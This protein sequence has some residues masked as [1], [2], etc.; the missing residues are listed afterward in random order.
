MA[1]SITIFERSAAQRQRQVQ[2]SKAG[3]RLTLR[4]FAI[5]EALQN[6]RFMTTPQIQLLFWDRTQGGRWGQ[7]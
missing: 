7:L 4:D 6:A 3:L 2:P 1:R 5:L